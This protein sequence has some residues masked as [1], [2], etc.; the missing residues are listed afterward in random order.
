[1]NN[2][3]PCAFV[4]G[5]PVKFGPDAGYLVVETDEGELVLSVIRETYYEH[6]DAPNDA[7]LSVRESTTITRAKKGDE[8][9]S[10]LYLL[11]MAQDVCKNICKR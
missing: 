9:Y 4:N 7:F 3:I 8:N 1:M 5:N 2:H 11:M 10:K 6:P